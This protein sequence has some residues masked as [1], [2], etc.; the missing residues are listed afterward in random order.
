MAT[1]I[2]DTVN[3]CFEDEKGSLEIDI[4]LN[5]E[6]SKEDDNEGISKP[7]Q[8]ETDRASMYIF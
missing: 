3:P 5:E 7:L 2:S 1:A 6:K 4:E 8:D